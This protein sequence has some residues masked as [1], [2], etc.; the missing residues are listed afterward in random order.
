MGHQEKIP[1]GAAPGI[2]ATDVAC[3]D[4]MRLYGVRLYGGNRQP[5][6]TT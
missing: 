1:D 6:P 5:T 4:D 3:V 2:G